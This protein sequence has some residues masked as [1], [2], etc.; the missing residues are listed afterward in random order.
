M[1][2]GIT[3]L[4]YLLVVFGI[5]PT[6]SDIRPFISGLM[7]ILLIIATLVAIA[8]VIGWCIG[9]PNRRA[10]I[11]FAIGSSL[12][13][14]P[15]IMNV[16]INSMIISDDVIVDIILD[17]ILSTIILAA[18]GTAFAVSLYGASKIGTTLQCTQSTLKREGE[19]SSKKCGNAR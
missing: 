8:G 15:V 16:I 3:Y 14:I 17:A 4:T 13:F 1:V 2:F 10:T 12:T 6:P 5:F 7:L 9:R 19:K 18:L 11:F